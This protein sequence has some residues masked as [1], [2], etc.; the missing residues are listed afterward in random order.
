MSLADDSHPK[1]DCSSHGVAP[2]VVERADGVWP[3][4][5]RRRGFDRRVK[6]HLVFMDHRTGFDR[7]KRSW[8]FG[9]L[10]DSRWALI[11]LL[12]LLN[13]FSLLDGVL[14]ALELRLGIAKEGNPLFAHVIQTNGFLAAGLKVA[15]MLVVS[16]V[17]WR[18]REHRSILAIVPFALALY[19]AVLAYHFGSLAGFY[20]R[21]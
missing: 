9:T 13:V 6:R 12:V 8:F 21:Q 7:R 18:W 4:V 1:E 5:E 20:G 14:T 11:S 2:T 15:V 3:L 17:I 10:R 19:A 16:A